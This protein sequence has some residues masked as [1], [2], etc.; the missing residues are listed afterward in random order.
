MVGNIFFQFFKL[1][2]ILV[3]VYFAV[4]NLF[5]LVISHLFLLLLLVLLVF[6]L[7]NYC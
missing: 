3:I 6:D 2:L 7:N 5:S 1:F 4:Q